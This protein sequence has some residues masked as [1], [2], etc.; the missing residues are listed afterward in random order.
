MIGPKSKV[1]AESKD[2]SNIQVL[3]SRVSDDR[4]VTGRLNKDGCRVSLQEISQD[5]VIVDLDKP[6]SPLSQSDARCDYLLVV[7]G[8]SGGPEWIVVLELKKGSLD[9][10]KVTGQLQAGAKTAERLT[11]ASIP[12]AFRPVA[13]VGSVPKGQRRALKTINI[14]LRGKQEM[15]RLLKC[16]DKLVNILR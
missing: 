2:R 16:G 7:E 4:L 15:P 11:D 8:N 3:R 5:R 9:V 13:A 6:G 12:R 1:K 14:T 10:S